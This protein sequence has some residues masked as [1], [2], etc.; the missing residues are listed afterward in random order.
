MKA[1]LL[2]NQENL[3]AVCLRNIESDSRTTIEHIIPQSSTKE[4]AMSYFR[5]AVIRQNVVV[6]ESFHENV[7]IVSPPFPHIIAYYN[8]VAICDGKVAD[9]GSETHC[10]IRRK[11]F[12]Y[13]VYYFEDVVQRFLYSSL[14]DLFSA[15]EESACNRSFIESYQL[16]TPYLRMIRKCWWAIKDKSDYGL[17]TIVAASED[18]DLRLDILDSILLYIGFDDFQSLK[19]DVYWNQ[20]ILYKAFYYIEFTTP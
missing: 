4:E 18:R 3:C 13:P 9:A 1:V 15:C 6:P 17:D 12:A 20:L 2:I 7:E 14:G 16:N 5:M 8:L 19:V 10:K 11:E